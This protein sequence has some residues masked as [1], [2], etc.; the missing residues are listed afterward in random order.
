MYRIVEKKI[1][2][3]DL[4]LFQVEAPEIA[5]KA[6]PGQFIILRVDD[7]GEGIPLTIVDSDP[8]NGTITIVFQEVGRST[9]ELG[10]LEC[11]AGIRD[12]VGPLGK[13][14]EIKNY[15]KVICAGGGVGIASL[16]PITRA[17]FA[18]G[19]FVTCMIGARNAASLIREEEIRKVSHQLV[20]TTE[21]GSKGFQ[22]LITGPLRTYLERE[23]YDRAVVI[24]PLGMM[25]AVCGITKEFDL[26]TVAG[27]NPVMADGPGLCGACRVQVGNDTQFAWVD[28][29]EF[30]GHRIDWNIAEQ[31]AKMFA[32]QEN[33][34]M[35]E[36][37]GECACRK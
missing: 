31:R 27:M 4:K 22:A 7:R 9:R 19:N 18:A 10:L 20:I 17:L 12:V 16:Y 11:G 23:K 5:N 2:G 30:D 14:F 8:L 25:K 36:W 6:L 15:G 26:P 13:P 3:I 32:A 29:P 1:L 35:G 33:M 28:G 24:G 34:A 21:D 37:E